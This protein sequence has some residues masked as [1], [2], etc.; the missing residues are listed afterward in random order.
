[1]IKVMK[2]K[3]CHNNPQYIAVF[4]YSLIFTPGR[5][6]SVYCIIRIF[7][8]LSTLLFGQKL[9]ATNCIRLLDSHRDGAA[10]LHSIQ[11][12]SIAHDMGIRDIA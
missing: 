9:I 5:T 1:M 3:T 6:T 10:I 2:S 8:R 12:L 11:H 4:Q 7:E